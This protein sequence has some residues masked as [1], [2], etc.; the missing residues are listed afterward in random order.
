MFFINLLPYLEPKKLFLFDISEFQVRQMK[1]YTELIKISNSY[2]DFL[3]N[4]FSR[5]FTRDL[6]KFIKQEVDPEIY[7]RTEKLITDKEAFQATI[8]KIASAS[9]FPLSSDITALKIRDN[10]M[11]QSIT[12]LAEDRFKPGPGTNTFYYNSLLCESFPK[13]KKLLTS[14]SI[15]VAGLDSKEVMD[16]LQND[17]GVIYVS[18]IGEENWLEGKYTDES[19]ESVAASGKQLSKA[20]QKQWTDSYIGFK[21]FLDKVHSQFWLIDSAGNIFNS[22]ELLME[23]SDSHLWLWQSLQ[24][25]LKGEVLEIIH[26]P[27]GTWGFNEHLKTRNWK[28]FLNAKP[29]ATQFQTVVLHILMGNGLQK[30]E[31]LQV[32]NKAGSFAQR[33]IIIEHYTL[34]KNHPSTVNTYADELLCLISSARLVSPEIKIFFSGTTTRDT[35]YNGHQK[36]LLRNIVIVCDL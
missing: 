13:I 16:T 19:I 36:E 20:F 28:S 23:R 3:E 9:P 4:I 18:N 26:A 10:S 21:S 29:D 14:A 34:G 15:S 30:D 25:H 35:S 11:C 1:V 2:E 5:R 22:V 17:N 6:D 24:P 32:L 27:D 33:V 12:M 8:G 7:A 31:F